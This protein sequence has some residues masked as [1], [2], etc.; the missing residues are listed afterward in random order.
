MPVLPNIDCISFNDGL[1]LFRIC[2]LQRPPEVTHID[3]VKRLQEDK[4]LFQGKCEF[5]YSECSSTFPF[6]FDSQHKSIG[7]TPK[8]NDYLGIS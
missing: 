1:N 8:N 5:K 4:Y 2:L 6:I 7:K 3:K